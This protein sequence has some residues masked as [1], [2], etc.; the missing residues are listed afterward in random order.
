MEGI[1]PISNTISTGLPVVD[2]I[3]SGLVARLAPR[4]TTIAIP[5]S[6]DTP[7][8]Q[9][10]NPISSHPPSI[11]S[12]PTN[13]STFNSVE[14]WRKILMSTSHCITKSPYTKYLSKYTPSQLAQ[15]FHRMGPGRS[16]ELHV[17]RL[18]EPSSIIPVH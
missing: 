8:P 14:D 12:L 5:T 7:S 3:I 16:P 10:L 2:L 6:I 11:P 1:D 18:C 15:Q 17:L 9:I 4:N 13:T